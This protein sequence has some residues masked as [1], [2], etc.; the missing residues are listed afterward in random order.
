MKPSEFLAEYPLDSHTQMLVDDANNGKPELLIRLL[1]TTISAISGI[2]AS[3]G[4]MSSSSA[5]GLVHYHRSKIR[6]LISLVEK[7]E[8]RKSLKQIF[9]GDEK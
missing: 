7:P 5:T 3:S 4:K 9:I 6:A 2:R 1:S 8:L